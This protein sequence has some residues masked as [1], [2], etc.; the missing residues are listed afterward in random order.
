MC[1]LQEAGVSCVGAADPVPALHHCHIPYC[2]LSCWCFS[3]LPCDKEASGS[4]R[5]T[6]TG[7]LCLLRRVDE[8]TKLSEALQRHLKL[9]AG[10]AS[11][12]MLLQQYVDAGLEH[13]GL[14]LKQE[15]RPVRSH[16]LMINGPVQPSNASVCLVGSQGCVVHMAQPVLWLSPL[17]PNLLTGK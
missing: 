2:V 6:L 14:L 10:Q 3:L 15:H 11:M 1:L 7:L 13:L 12:H 4:Y 8:Q 9:Q 16:L 17:K 5:R